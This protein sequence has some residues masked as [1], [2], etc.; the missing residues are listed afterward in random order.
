LAQMGSTVAEG[1]KD[2][3]KNAFN[4][5]EEKEKVKE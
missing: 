4:E 3:E 1:E 5:L 2:E